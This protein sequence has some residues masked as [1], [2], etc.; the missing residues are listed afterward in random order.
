MML[1]HHNSHSHIKNGSAGRQVTFFW[2][3]SYVNALDKITFHPQAL[4]SENSQNHNPC[5]QMHTERTCILLD[6]VQKSAN[7]WTD[8]K[9]SVYNII[10]HYYN[11]YYLYIYY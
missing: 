9:Y 2:I 7:T 10:L 6:C 11:L 8:R 4:I 5:I 1:Y 3:N